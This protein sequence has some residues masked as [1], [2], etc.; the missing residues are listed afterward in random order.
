MAIRCQIVLVL[1]EGRKKAPYNKDVN[2][3]RWGAELVGATTAAWGLD[4][5]LH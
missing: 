2:M 1:S 4:K 5:S 3:K